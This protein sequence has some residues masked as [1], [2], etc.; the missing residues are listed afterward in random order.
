MSG[1]VIIGIGQTM[2]GDDAVGVAVVE[3]WAAKYPQHASHPQVATVLLRLPGLALLDHIS[4]YELAIL[5]DAVL[6]GPDVTPGSL[7]NLKPEDLAS[8]TGGLGAAHGWGVAETLELARTL[9]RDDIPE[10]IKILGIGGI[11]V[12]LGA[13]LSPEVEA[14]MPEAVETLDRMVMDFLD[15]LPDAA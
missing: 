10:E 3:A 11:Q 4:R 9:G 13:G 15:H 7:L 12:E 14:A 1:L 2:R 8:F 5:V 6:G